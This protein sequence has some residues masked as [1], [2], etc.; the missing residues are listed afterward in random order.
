V[1]VVGVPKVP[2]PRRLY[3]GV[4]AEEVEALGSERTSGASRCVSRR[5]L[6]TCG[7]LVSFG[8]GR[9]ARFPAI[10]SNRK[11]RGG[12]RVQ[13]KERGTEI[14]RRVTSCSSESSVYYDGNSGLW[15]AILAAWGRD[16]EREE[17]GNGEE[18]EGYL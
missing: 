6:E 2:G 17:G 4:R 14:G 11:G 15:R 7:A 12:A 8:R 16:L 1:D 13:G 5:W 3:D 10:K 9:A 18:S